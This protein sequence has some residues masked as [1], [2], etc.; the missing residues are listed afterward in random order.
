MENKNTLQQAQEA[1]DYI[2]NKIGQLA[3]TIALTLG[4]GLSEFAEQLSEK[5]S[6][7]FDEIPHFKK[8][9]Y[10]PG[11]IIVG[12]LNDIA[13][14]CF[15]GRYHYYEGFSMQDI[16]FPIKVVKLIGIKQIIMTNAS[17]A[18]S[19]MLNA[20]DLVIIRDHFSF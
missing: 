14:L 2:K 11:Q 18:I 8:T 12:K 7:S 15:K 19:K 16:V 13:V 9:T 20:G 5:I 4:S 17:G 10:H 3:P 6:I 1:C